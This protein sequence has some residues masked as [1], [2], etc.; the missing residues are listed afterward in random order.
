MM[1]KE[2][3]EE[4]RLGIIQYINQ[5]RRADV[6][7]LAQ[8]FNVTEVTIRRDLILLEDS[9]K[10]VRTHGGAISCLDRSIWQTTN[11]RARLE[12]ETAEKERIANYVA[13]LISDGE[14]IFLDSGS[15]SLL[16]ARALLSHKRLMVVSNSPSVAQ[17]LAGVNENKV[18]ITG[19]EL[20]K[21]TDSIIGTSCEEFLK[22]YRT[23]KAILGISGI[24]IPDGYFAANPQEAAV[25]RIMG[26]NAKRT[27]Y[28][29]DSSKIGT[30]AFTFVESL[31]NTG[32]LITDTNISE[33]NLKLLKQY[34]ADVVTV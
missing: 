30:T 7:E 6:Y 3:V 10:L 16:I 15:T 28:A 12:N 9:G 11:I 22:Q 2:F 23:D 25:K 1:K 33:D 27:I 13:S 32:L 19:G 21:N 26:N 24:L 14:S 18:L 5:K 29:A 4:R 20:E 34:G 17:T 8:E 31:K